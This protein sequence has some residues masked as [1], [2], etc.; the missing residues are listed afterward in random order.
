[1]PSIN[2]VFENQT[3][4]SV[5]I[6]QPS[7]K[8]IASIG[9]REEVVI[10]IYTIDLFFELKVLVIIILTLNEFCVEFFL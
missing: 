3:M 6:T 5:I 9:K 2:W 1:M 4:V 7:Q 10:Y 8:K